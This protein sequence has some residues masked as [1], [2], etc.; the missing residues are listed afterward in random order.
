MFEKIF[1]NLKNK[2]PL[3]HNITNYVTAND[4]ANI[5]LACG[6]SPIMADDAAEVAEITSIC[7]ALVINI[8]TLNSRTIESMLIS[9]KRAAELGKPVILDPVGAGASALRTETAMRLI[10]EI[11]F[12]VIRGNASEIK[13]LC[14]GA[15]KSRGVDVSDSDSDSDSEAVFEN[16]K[17]LSSLT[18]ATVAV[19]GK[20]DFVTDGIRG[21]A[22][23]NGHPLMKRVTGCGCMLSSL[24]GG[25]CGAN[26]D[27]IFDAAVCAV[28]FMGLCGEYAAQNYVGTGSLRTGI[29]DEASNMTAEK[30]NRGIKIE[31]R[32]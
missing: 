1:E 32:Q 5:L 9:G 14:G 25:F 29:I 20:T 31:F 23:S 2:A 30:L 18:G 13:I 19:T 17:R 21:A 24:L 10:N 3:V 7:D 4:C 26:P 16:A 8:G 12:S 6:A 11:K 22:I 15:G 27:E 28:A